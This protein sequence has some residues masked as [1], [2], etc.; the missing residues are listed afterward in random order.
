MLFR[1][2]KR[3]DCNHGNCFLLNFTRFIV[4]QIETMPPR[5]TFQ[6]HVPETAT[7][8]VTEAHYMDGDNIVRGIGSLPALDL[9]KTDPQILMDRAMLIT[10]ASQNH[11]AESVYMVGSVQTFW[12]NK[13]IIY[14]ALGLTQSGVQQVQLA[15]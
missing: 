12:P 3:E 9:D 11:L 2:L 4:T 7:A 15:E 14:Y 5:A 10:G 8:H 13:T 1:E 6:K